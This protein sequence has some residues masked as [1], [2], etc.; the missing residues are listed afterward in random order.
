M[1]ATHHKERIWN[2]AAGPSTLPLPILEEAQRDLLNWNGS[3]RSVME[4]SHRSKDVISLMQKT[5]SDLRDLLSIPQQYKILM[6]QGGGTLQ[7]SCVPLNL[8]RLQPSH[9]AD[10]VVTGTFSQK[11]Y[12]EALRY[13][14]NIRLAVDAKPSNY[15]TIPD[16]DSWS[17]REESSYL[18][19]VTNE[20][21]Q[22]VQFNFVPTVK[23]EKQALVADMSSDFLSRP[24][25]VSKYSVIF[26]G[27]QKNIGIAGVTFVIVRDDVLG[28]SFPFTPG[29]LDYQSF[30]QE[31][32]M[33]NTPPVWS[34]YMSSLYLQYLKSI[35]GVSAMEQMSQRKA[36]LIYDVIDTHPAFYRNIIPKHCRSNMNISF[37]LNNTS[38]EEKFLKEAQ[39]NRLFEL[40]G[41]RTVGGMRASLYNGMAEEGV[42]VLA[43]FM[44]EF[45]NENE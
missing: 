26:A 29:M 35:G 30:A 28:K 34:I 2:F 3:G 5:E 8:L 22:G 20:T 1:S 13:S 40:K 37:H 32:S 19:Y 42:Q 4:S 23:N 7:F 39:K 27:A 16:I 6:M 14:T 17:I 33:P 24:I 9:G 36:S 31:E 12:N 15:T 21:P 44:N 43:H 10:Y 18:Y 25:D 38:L 41:H 45:A 11:A